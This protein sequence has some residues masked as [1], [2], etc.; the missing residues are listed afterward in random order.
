MTDLN[1]VLMLADALVRR[2]VRAATASEERFY[3]TFGAQPR[4]LRHLRDRRFRR[5]A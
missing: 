1:T 5:P 4:L 3:A 2:D